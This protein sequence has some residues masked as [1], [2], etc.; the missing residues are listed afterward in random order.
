MSPSE[1]SGGL[2]L[3]SA[4]RLARGLSEA[5]GMIYF[6]PYGNLWRPPTPHQ[7]K[8]LADKIAAWYALVTTQRIPRPP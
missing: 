4:P 3:K 2:A 5:V 8:S 1:P 7:K 6:G